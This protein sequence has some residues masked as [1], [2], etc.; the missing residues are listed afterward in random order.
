MTSVFDCPD[1]YIVSM[2][3]SRYGRNEQCFVYQWRKER[4]ELSIF[5]NHFEVMLQANIYF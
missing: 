4:L 1:D 2:T 3:G 5:Y